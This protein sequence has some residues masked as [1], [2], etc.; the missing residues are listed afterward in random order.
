MN[1]NVFTQEDLARALAF[2][3]KYEPQEEYCE[4]D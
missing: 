4:F 3:E 2:A 1:D